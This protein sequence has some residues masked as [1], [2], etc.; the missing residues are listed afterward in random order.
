MEDDKKIII[1][2]MI[3][4][5]QIVDIPMSD[6]MTEMV[7][8]NRNI[9]IP[10]HMFLSNKGYESNDKFTNSE[11]KAL[12]LYDSGMKPKEFKNVVKRQQKKKN[13]KPNIIIE[14]NKTLVFN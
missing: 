14:H 10:L 4:D 11:N 1:S 3:D 13:V 2:E 9:Q 5:S 7:L 6:L 12:E 8:S